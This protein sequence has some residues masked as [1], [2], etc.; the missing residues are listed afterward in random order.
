VL[1]QGNLI[2]VKSIDEQCHSA[3]EIQEKWRELTEKPGIDIAVLDMPSGLDS[4]NLRG[5]MS[6][7]TTDAFLQVL[8]IVE[9]DKRNVIKQRQM[10]GIRSAQ[11]R[12]VA[13]GR[14][15]IESP[16]NFAE[17]VKLWE[18]AEITFDEALTRTGLKSA[19]F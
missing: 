9:E 13:M 5:L 1:K 11:A 3:E 7:L 12:G 19:T 15:R 18:H 14:P 8:S 17:V 10:E 6:T 16:D 4:G 2:Y